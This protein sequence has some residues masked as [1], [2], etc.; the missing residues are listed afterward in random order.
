MRLLLDENLPCALAPFLARQ[1]HDVAHAPAGTTD[2]QIIALAKKQRRALL[3]LDKDF[4][5]IINYPPKNYY[6]IVVLRVKR[7]DYPHLGRLLNKSLIKFS[8]KNLIGRLV[9]IQDLRMRIR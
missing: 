4:C 3:T 8:Q 2:S 1:G 6:G 7:F 5:N 9:I